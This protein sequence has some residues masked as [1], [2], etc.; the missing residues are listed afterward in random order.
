MIDYADVNV[1]LSG[2]LQT[3]S[4]LP[5][6]AFANID[7]APPQDTPYI[8]EKF[9]PATSTVRTFGNSSHKVMAT[10]LYAVTIYGVQ[11]VDVTPN[12]TLAT[13]IVTA[14]AGWATALTNGDRLRI[15]TDVLPTPGDSRNTGDGW[16]V[17]PINIFWEVESRLTVA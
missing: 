8:T 16:F 17:T 14:F 15:R 13:A 9:Q 1:K 11:G 12:N 4:A 7:E 10:G 5:V 3:V 2:R 6:I